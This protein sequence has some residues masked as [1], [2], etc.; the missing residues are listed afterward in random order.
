MVL[1]KAGVQSARWVEI[2]RCDVGWYRRLVVLALFCNASAFA[3]SAAK[4]ARV[5]WQEPISEMTFVSVP[6]GC[7]LMGNREAVAYVEQMSGQ[8]TSGIALPFDDERPQHQ[9]CVNAFWLGQTEVTQAQWLKVM[10]E[11][12]TSNAAPKQPVV[13]VTRSE[14]IRFAQRLTQLSGGQAT[15]RLPTE[16]EWEY[17]CRAGSPTE[18]ATSQGGLERFAWYAMEPGGK[19]TEP[20]VVGGLAANAFGL[21]DMLGNVW[22]WVADDYDAKGYAKHRLYNP[23]VRNKS[24]DAVIRGAS[25]RSMPVHVR[26]AKRSTYPVDQSMWTIGFRLL[27]EA[28]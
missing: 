10:G 4:P 7:F 21:H 26:C 23:L 25:Y 1:W 12:G 6:A 27:K 19:K 8:P 2:V 28:K 17:A 11:G 14:A 16:A 3:A 22:E 20:Q 5:D 13:S 15:Y 9:V 24:A 18:L